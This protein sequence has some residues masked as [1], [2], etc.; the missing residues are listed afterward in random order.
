MQTGRIFS[1]NKQVCVAEEAIMFTGGPA[2]HLW[3]YIEVL[4]GQVAKC[5][6]PLASNPADKWDFIFE[7][8]IRGISA[9]TLKLKIYFKHYYSKISF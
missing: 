2:L 9:S 3:V 5:L 7:I 1:A 4:E 8:S 6:T